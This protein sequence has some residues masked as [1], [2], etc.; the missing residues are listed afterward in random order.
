MKAYRSGRLMHTGGIPGTDQEKMF[1][2]GSRD[3]GSAGRPSAAE[4][5]S[6]SFFRYIFWICPDMLIIFLLNSSTWLVRVDM[7]LY[8]FFSLCR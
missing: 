6:A 2:S 1:G 7:A 3:E 4:N 5:Y 8:W